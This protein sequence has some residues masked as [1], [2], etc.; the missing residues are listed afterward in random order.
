MISLR[1]IA[2]QSD[3]KVF[4]DLL[5]KHNNPMQTILAGTAKLSMIVIRNVFFKNLM[6]KNDELVRAGKM[7]MF[8]RSEDEAL[9]A[10][11][12]SEII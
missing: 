10:I 5:G 2:K 8:V 12:R 7:P 6:T 4:E 1:A 3:R 11:A 9:L